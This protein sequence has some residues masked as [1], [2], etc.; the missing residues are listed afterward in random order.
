MK[1]YDEYL[2]QLIILV[3]DAVCDGDYPLAERLLFN[4]LLDEPGYAKLH[5][6]KAWMH[7][8]YQINKAL[9]DKHYKLALYFDDKYEDA[10]KGLVALY[11]ENKKY[12]ALEILFEN[13]KE[14][15]FLEKEYIFQN[16]GKLAEIKGNYQLA[17]Y[18]YREAL[19]HCLENDAL[20]SI[21]DNIKRSR[22]KY[23]KKKWKWLP[24]K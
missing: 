8:Y 6:F 19:M 13:V 22:L 24:I 23:F 2:E 15:K 3:E 16:L 4:G 18:Y 21:N 5:Y 11:F 7:H 10:F 1:T 17:V 20:K 9:A 12:K 14:K